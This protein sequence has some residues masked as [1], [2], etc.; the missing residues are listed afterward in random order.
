MRTASR[1]KTW[2]R[3]LYARPGRLTPELA[4]G[5]GVY[6]RLLR[7]AL[8]RWKHKL[9]ESTLLLL[10]GEVADRHGRTV[11]EMWPFSVER[12][13]LLM[14]DPGKHAASLTTLGETNSDDGRGGTPAPTKPK[15]ERALTDR[16]KLILAEMLA[17]GAVGNTTK[18]TRND[19]VRRIDKTKIGADFA[20]DFGAMWEAKYTDS[21]AGPE[22]G[23]WLSD[24][25]KAK[26]EALKKENEQ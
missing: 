3:F 24:K 13:G 10:V 26:A 12:F 17:M 4:E 25:G 16:Q 18:A 6:R 8:D 22:G 5:L 19:I 14:D 23:V 11:D 21:D 7:A 9:D 20:R 1:W 15:P 2:P